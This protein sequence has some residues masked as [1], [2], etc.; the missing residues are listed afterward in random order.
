[1]GMLEWRGWQ[2]EQETPET[3]ND[4]TQGD[5]LKKRT[6]TTSE[7]VALVDES[8]DVNQQNN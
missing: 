3:S 5:D 2:V 7:L 6:G 4:K 1:M 8:P